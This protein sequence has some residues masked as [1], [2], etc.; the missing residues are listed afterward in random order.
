[1]NHQGKTNKSPKVTYEPKTKHR[2]AR[3]FEFPGKSNNT[4]EKIKEKREAADLSLCFRKCKM[5]LSRD[6]AHK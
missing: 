6:T 4:P 2:V 1:M 5:Q 3:Q